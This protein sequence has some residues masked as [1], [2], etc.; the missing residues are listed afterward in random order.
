MCAHKIT[1]RLHC[2]A[3][4][5]AVLSHAWTFR[6]NIVHGG[7]G[8]V[9]KIAFNRAPLPLVQARVLMCPKRNILR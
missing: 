5:G 2:D 9:I 6:G 1:A 7:E 3:C 4:N 8:S